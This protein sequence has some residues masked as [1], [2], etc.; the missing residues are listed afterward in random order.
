MFPASYEELNKFSRVFG[1]G[2]ISIIEK[3]QNK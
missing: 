1:K 3:K 2:F